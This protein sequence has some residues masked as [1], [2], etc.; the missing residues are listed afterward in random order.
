M[1][2]ELAGALSRDRIVLRPPLATD[3]V[4]SVVIGVALTELGSLYS[5]CLAVCEFAPNRDRNAGNP[6]SHLKRVPIPARSKLAS[7][8][9][10]SSALRTWRQ[11][12][13]LVL[14]STSVAVPQKTQI[15]RLS[16]AQCRSAWR[17]RLRHIVSPGSQ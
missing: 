6:G 14:Y 10:V 9:R 3:T 11:G 5:S 17:C 13:E 8:H 12:V 7:R 1:I 15:V 4:S 2:G 16:Y